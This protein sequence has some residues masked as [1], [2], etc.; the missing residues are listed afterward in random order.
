MMV[1]NKKENKL[2]NI[3]N[4]KNGIITY[5]SESRNINIYYTISITETVGNK[6]NAIASYTIRR[7]YLD[8]EGAKKL[9]LNKAIEYYGTDTNQ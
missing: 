1:Y 6:L 8:E 2:L 9:V 7:N 4:T 5:Y 3:L